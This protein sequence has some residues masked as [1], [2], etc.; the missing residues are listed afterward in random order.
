MLLIVAV[1]LTVILVTELA[2][3]IR[4]Q[5]RNRLKSNRA[6][7]REAI[8]LNYSK[9]FGEQFLDEYKSYYKSLK[10]DFNQQSGQVPDFSKFTSITLTNGIRLTTSQPLRAK[11]QIIL[12]GGSTIFNAQVPNEK[13]IASLLQKKINESNHNATVYNF[14]KSGATTSDRLN[15]VFDKFLL[16]P[17]DMVINY[18]GVNDACINKLDFTPKT[19]S[20][21]LSVV[22]IN[23]ALMTLAKNLVVF[24]KLKPIS[25]PGSNKAVLNYV[26]KVTIPVI[27]EFNS[28]CEIRK[29]KFLAVLQPSAYCINTVEKKTR[30]YLKGFSN[31]PEVP[32]RIANKLIFFSLR[33]KKYFVDARQVFNENLE[34]NYTDWVHTTESGNRRICSFLFQQIS[35]R[36]WLV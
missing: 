20:L 11:Q 6:I 36:H 10:K 26:R 5:F 8:D 13:T 4:C 7:K 14:G 34:T 1:F 17:N 30:L 23:G 2:S 9:K 16:R 32:I 12:L 18:F 24:N 28:I 31:S 25:K 3:R 21:D 19:N 27:S 35:Q 15:V 22:M 29:I 33:E